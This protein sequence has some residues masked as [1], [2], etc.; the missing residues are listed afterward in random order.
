ML[1]YLKITI[2]DKKLIISVYTKLADSHLYLDD[3]SCH[4]AKSI[5]G[6]ST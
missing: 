2:N 6:I 3:A 4:L 5:N 1:L